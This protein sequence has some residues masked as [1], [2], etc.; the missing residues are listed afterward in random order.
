MGLVLGW[1]ADQLS[2][3]PPSGRFTYGYGRSTQIASLIN[4]LL[5]FG[6]GLLLTFTPCVLPMIPILSGPSRSVR[7]DPAG[8]APGIG[9]GMRR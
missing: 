8:Y 9:G 7:A 4:G 6:A 2:R 3:R 5:I 1:G